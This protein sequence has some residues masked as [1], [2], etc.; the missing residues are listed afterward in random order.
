MILWLGKGFSLI[1]VISAAMYGCGL[2]GV[3]GHPDQ[4]LTKPDSPI[5]EI[6]LKDIDADEENVN[7][8]SPKPKSKAK[9]KAKAKAKVTLEP[10]MPHPESRDDSVESASG[11]SD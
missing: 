6:V 8:Q 2:A 3:T 9:S 10:A 7:A 5:N 11:T 1:P 4:E